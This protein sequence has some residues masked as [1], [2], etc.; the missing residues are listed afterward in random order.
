MGIESRGF[1][2]MDRQ[3]QREI[4]SKGGRTAHEKGL[5]HQWTP[6]KAR[7]AGRKGGLARHARAAK[8]EKSEA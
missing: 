6:E 8:A 7:E 4:A 1:A 3:K 2:S 5:A